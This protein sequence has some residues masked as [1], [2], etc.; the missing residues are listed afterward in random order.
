MEE[1]KTVN[2]DTGTPPISS[3]PIICSQTPHALPLRPPDRDRRLLSS[4]KLGLTPRFR[5]KENK[6]EGSE[7]LIKVS[8]FAE[9][10]KQRKLT[11]EYSLLGQATF[12]EWHQK[13]LN[14]DPAVE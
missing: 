14:R 12:L 3:H 13:R 4:V 1:S 2:L 7:S 5:L 8:E 11:Q 9:A 10:M 6:L